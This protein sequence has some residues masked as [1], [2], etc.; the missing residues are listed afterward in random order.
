MLL[1]ICQIILLYSKILINYGKLY[2]ILSNL[3]MYPLYT[4]QI[5]GLSMEELEK[6]VYKI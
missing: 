5:I 1:I 6:Y 3:S 4:I 2:N